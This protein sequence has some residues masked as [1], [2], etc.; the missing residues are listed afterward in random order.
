MEMLSILILYILT[1]H[2][3]TPHTHTDA[4]GDHTPGFYDIECARLTRY[5]NMA[6]AEMVNAR[7][8]YD[9]DTAIMQLCNKYANPGTTISNAQTNA[10]KS[11]QIFSE[12]FRTATHI[13]NDLA[14]IKSHIR[15]NK[16]CT[17]ADF[18]YE[19]AYR[20]HTARIPSML[21]FFVKGKSK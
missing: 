8:Q 3:Y 14:Q 12:K 6:H 1:R 5:F 19:M 16:N 15:K 20:G 17:A 18:A 10:I 4:T 21:S 9:I 11:E 7:K 2:L 13:Q